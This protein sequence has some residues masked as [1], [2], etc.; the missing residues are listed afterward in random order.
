MTIHK[1]IDFQVPDWGELQAPP[2]GRLSYRGEVMADSPLMYLRMGESSGSMA[3]DETGQH[4]AAES[5]SLNWGVPGPLAFD[6]DTAVDSSGTGG[7][8]VSETGWLPVGSVE[9]TIELWF[10]PN[11]STLAYR[12]INYGD[13]DVGKRINF[14]YT[15]VEVSVAVS[16]CR[17]GALGL[18]L[19]DQWHHFVL[20][21][22]AARHA[23]MNFFFT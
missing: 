19:A 17:Y 7:L 1:H 22:R 15:A 13:S 3:Y 6:N 20:V 4:H 9:R 12:G 14:I 5:G 18:S 16:N 8:V 2:R 10:K 11:S 23:A 21:F